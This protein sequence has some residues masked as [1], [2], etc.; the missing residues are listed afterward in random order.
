[1]A[2][3]LEITPQALRQL[4]AF[5]AAVQRRLRPRI[6]ALAD[7]PR[8]RGS[9]KLQGHERRYRLRVGDYHV[10]YEVQDDVLLVLVI[11][12]GHRPPL[13]RSCHTSAFG[14]I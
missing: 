9:E 6:D 13:H 5:P 4:Q 8:P 2:Y 3:R 1:V 12:L 14:N 11:R 10:I 7:D